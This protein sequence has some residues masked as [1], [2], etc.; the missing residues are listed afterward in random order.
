MRYSC[1][2]AFEG[3][4]GPLIFG[5]NVQFWQKTIWGWNVVP[6]WGEAM[7]IPWHRS[8]TRPGRTTQGRRCNFSMSRYRTVTDFQGFIIKP[9]FI[10]TWAARH[11]HALGQHHD[12]VCV[13]IPWQMCLQPREESPP[14]PPQEKGQ[15][16]GI[17]RSLE[18]LIQPCP[19]SPSSPMLSKPDLD[20]PICLLSSVIGKLLLFCVKKECQRGRMFIKYLQLQ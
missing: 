15:L 12:S 19:S 14:P 1:A 2:K 6:S 8:A 5:R 17:C 10:P 20:N 16:G 18:W 11:K 9:V 7:L 4:T 13:L 3:F